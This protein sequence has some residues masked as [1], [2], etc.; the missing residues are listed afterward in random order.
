MNEKLL[1]AFYHYVHRNHR[2]DPRGCEGCLEGA[3]FLT[4]PGYQ[5]T[6]EPVVS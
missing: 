2:F 1:R 3:G 4:M 5:G 6:D